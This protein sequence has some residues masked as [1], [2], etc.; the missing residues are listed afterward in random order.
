MSGSSEAPAPGEPRPAYH[1]SL[2]LKKRFAAKAAEL[3]VDART[4]RRWVKAVRSVGVAGL[5]DHRAVRSVDPFAGVDERWLAMCRLVL[6]EH[7]DASR[8]TQDLV[9]ARITARLAA[10]YGEGC[11]PTPGRR[12]AGVVLRELARGTNAFVGS[13]TGKRSIAARPKGVYGRLRPTRPGEFVLLDTTPLDV[14]AMEPL[15]LRWVR[16]KLTV[17]LDLYSRCITGLR[18]SPVSTKSVDAAMVLDEILMPNTVRGTGGGLLRMPE[19]QTSSS[20]LVT[21]PA[22][23]PLVAAKTRGPAC[24]RWRRKRSSLTTGRSTCP[25]T[26]SRYAPVLASRYS[27]PAH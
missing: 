6:D 24:R 9:L 25:S 21:R 22:A 14:F 18:V 5:I 11:V 7:V 17:A 10:E 27:R 12:R 16:V 13:T 19:C 20:W 4:L 26:C 3:G 1:P 15:T 2:R 23:K 8:P